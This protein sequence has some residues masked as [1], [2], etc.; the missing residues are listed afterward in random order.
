MNIK[1]VLDGLDLKVA[2]K[3]SLRKFI[4][5]ETERL[6]MDYYFERAK[7]SPKGETI[8][9]IV[10]DKELFGCQRGN[11]LEVLSIYTGE[12]LRDAGDQI[13]WDNRLPMIVF[14]ENRNGHDYDLNQPLLSLGNGKGVG[15]NGHLG[16]NLDT[17]RRTI[18]PATEKEIDKFFLKA[19]LVGILAHLM[20]FWYSGR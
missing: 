5:E 3:A 14:I 4:E 1:E 15:M 7:V 2:F 13:A 9:N 20:R 17:R 19:N 6:K 16:N 10:L 11:V 8:R 12:D 18:R